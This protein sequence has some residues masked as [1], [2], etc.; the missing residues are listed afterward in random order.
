[1]NNLTKLINDRVSLTIEQGVAHVLLNRADKMN[2]LDQKMFEALAATAKQIAVDKTVRVVVI[3]GAGKAFCAGLDMENFS[4]L[5]DPNTDNSEVVSNLEKR[6]EGIANDVQYPVW[7]WH[8]LQVPVI[9]AVH[10]VAVGGGLQIALAADMRY[11]AAETRFSIMEI[12]WGLVPDMSSTQLMRHF[13]A[14]DIVRELTYTGRVFKSDEAKEY[15]F[16][17]RVCDDPLEEAMQ[18]AKQIA[19]RNPHA[20]RACKRILNAAPYQSEAEG[21]LMESREQ[22]RIIGSSNQLEAVMAELQK[23]LPQFKDS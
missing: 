16:V 21:L 18:I 1:M 4:S 22:D 6:T 12:K 19:S 7:A 14:D 5:L 13:A 9:A 23:R 10:G 20:I 3:S 2:A 8:E 17:T 15:G 11:A